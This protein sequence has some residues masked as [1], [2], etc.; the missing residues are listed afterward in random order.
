MAVQAKGVC[1]TVVEVEVGISHRHAQGF[2]Q[3]RQF[4]AWLEALGQLPAIP[5]DSPLL[6]DE[7]FTLSNVLRHQVFQPRLRLFRRQ[8]RF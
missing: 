5:M 4:G 8:D 2:G 1:W 3:Q 7:I 6:R